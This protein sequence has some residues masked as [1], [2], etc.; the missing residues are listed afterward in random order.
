MHRSLLLTLV[1]VVAAAPLLAAC[2]DDDTTTIRPASTDGR[3]TSSLTVH[4]T[5][6][7]KFDADS[8]EAE[9][10][11][12]DVT[13]VN[14]GTVAH[15]L[16]IKDVDG[17]KLSIGGEDEGSVELEPGD[18]TL[19]CDVAGHEVGGHGRRAHRL[20]APG[21]VASRMP[22]ALELVLAPGYLDDLE[23][24]PIDDLRAMRAECDEVETGLSL[25]RAS[26]RA[27]S[28]SSAASSTAGPAAA[29][30][31]TSATCSTASPRSLADRSQAPG[32]G[33]LSALLA[34]EPSTPGSR[35]SSPRSSGGAVLDP[36]GRGRRR[37]AVARRTACAPSRPS[38]RATAGPCSTRLDALQA[39][40]ARRYRTGD[41]TVDTLL[42]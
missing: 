2:G 28:T 3:P 38:S 37:A 36:S 39:E 17:F 26:C 40:I 27:T 29:S 18:Y 41:E 21:S 35:P 14:D 13:Y 33:R 23:A 30:P 5:D 9:A 15:T 25:L 32:P 24:R 4:G 10:G 42:S 7:L 20:V 22:A 1:A 6:D 31:A 16:L 12:V 34:P 8:Y 19:Y 11:D